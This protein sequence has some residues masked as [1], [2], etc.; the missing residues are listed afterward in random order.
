MERMTDITIDRGPPGGY[1]SIKQGGDV[2]LVPPCLGQ[3]V[4]DA[5]RTA[6][7][8]MQPPGEVEDDPT[9]RAMNKFFDCYFKFTSVARDRGVH[10]ADMRLKMFEIYERRE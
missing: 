8:D 1:V 6:S 10:D 3:E 2:V 9:E 4:A 5:I 7:N